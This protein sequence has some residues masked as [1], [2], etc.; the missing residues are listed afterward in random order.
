MSPCSRNGCS[1]KN[2]DIGPEFVKFVPMRNLIVLF[3]VWLI[4]GVTHLGATT[5]STLR[6]SNVIYEGDVRAVRLY[7]Q[8]SGFSFPILTLGG[9][10][11]LVLEFDQIKSER[12][13]Y[14]YTLIH[15]DAKWNPTA[16]SKTQFL[17][18]MFLLVTPTIRQNSRL[19]PKFLDQFQR[20]LH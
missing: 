4:G 11:S 1:C 15:C 17:D 6:M 19:Q 13:F 12:D 2:L 3:F 9:G 8:N 18:G 20:R 7:Q 16:L 10:E 5:D 14:Q